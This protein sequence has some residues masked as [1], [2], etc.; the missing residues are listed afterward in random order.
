MILLVDSIM[1]TVQKH[2]LRKTDEQAKSGAPAAQ[3][4]DQKSEQELSEGT[5]GRKKNDSPIISNDQ[6]EEQQPKDI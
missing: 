4:T 6:I 3:N 2:A 5:N 1:S